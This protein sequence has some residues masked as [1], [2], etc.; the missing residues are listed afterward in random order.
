[1]SVNLSARSN[2]TFLCFTLSI[3]SSLNSLCALSNFVKYLLHL[4]CFACGEVQ[5]P[6]F[7]SMMVT[8]FN[9]VS[10]FPPYCIFLMHCHTCFPPKHSLCASSAFSLNNSFLDSLCTSYFFA[11]V[12]DLVH[13]L[14]LGTNLDVLFSSFPAL[15]PL[16]QPLMYARQSTSLTSSHYTQSFTGHVSAALVSPIP[17]TVLSLNG[18]SLHPCHPFCLHSTELHQTVS[19]PL[20]VSSHT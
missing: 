6:P 13:S 11:A 8:F 3:S 18:H 1:M 2:L 9:E 20:H 16:S 12:L 10:P 5:G 7:S 15:L 4:C 17:K 14:T 19:L